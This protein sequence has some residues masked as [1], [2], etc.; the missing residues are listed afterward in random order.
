MIAAVGLLF[1]PTLVPYV[2]TG[3]DPS[4]SIGINMATARRM[5]F[6]RDIIF[7]FGPLGF[8][9]TPALIVPKFGVVAMVFR[10]ALSLTF[11]W[12]VARALLRSVPWPVAAACTWFLQW[13]VVGGSSGGAETMLI[14]VLLLFFGL[15]DALAV[16]ETPLGRPALIGLGLAS[17]TTLLMK[18][19]AGLL[20]LLLVCGFVLAEGYVLRRSFGSTFAA[21]GAVIAAALASAIG[22][23]I[24]LRQ[25]LGA[26]GAWVKTSVDV[27]S[28]YQAAMVSDAPVQRSV[29]HSVLTL[30]FVSVVV[31]AGSIFFGRERRRSLTIGVLTLG[32]LLVFAKQSFTRYDDG[33]LQRV[34]TCA[35][36]VLVSA[37]STWRQHRS[38]EK[39]LERGPFGIRRFR[40]RSP[41]AW[42]L[43]AVVLTGSLYSANVGS[44]LVAALDP[45]TR[46]WRNVVELASS[47]T[48]RD[49]VVTRQ[50][51]FLPPE[52]AIPAEVRRA[53]SEG[54]VHI[55]PTET[56]IAWIFPEVRW[57]PL[58]VFQSYSAY[59]GALDDVNARAYK[60]GRGTDVVLYRGGFRV[61]DRLARFE[62][63]AAQVAFVCNFRPRVL[64]DAWQV[65]VRRPDGSGCS[66]TAENIAELR[67]RMGQKVTLPTLPDD[68]IVVASFSGLEPSLTQRIRALALRAPKLWFEVAKPEPDEPPHRFVI[69]TA[70]QEHL[71][72]L[73]RCL[74][75]A[76]GTYDTRTID[77]FTLRNTL[78]ARTDGKVGS[79]YV[80]KLTA[81]SY[82]CPE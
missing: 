46:S 78:R 73:P 26:L 42:G 80:V 59:S 11:G 67:V 32:T 81:Y 55:E 18:F 16:R 52:L 20:C 79:D 49:A 34:Y 23:W 41:F 22:W 24:V 43:L 56:S 30:V 27:F 61:D 72:S 21:L 17:A 2:G 12:L 77:T 35:A 33:H 54:G 71:V 29:L 69:G 31:I 60:G 53:L 45:D 62:S 3:L 28:G 65:F 63:P 8:L 64:T 76:W 66:P 13:A 57:K 15:V 82:R 48:R 74:R 4:W 70:R 50:R 51:T 10:F 68:A 6:G 75:G 37:V 44:D 25:P 19:D 39:A 38:D 7:T 5:V 40:G 58:P 9:A 1:M 47:G 14:P 36:V